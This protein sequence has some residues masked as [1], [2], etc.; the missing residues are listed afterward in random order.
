M[1]TYSVVDDEQ[2]IMM[3]IS[4]II[5]CDDEYGGDD[6]VMNV[7]STVY[8]YSIVCAVYSNLKKFNSNWP[9]NPYNLLIFLDK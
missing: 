6:D 5:N 4:Y 9:L 1:V 2:L 3:M 7:L 8:M